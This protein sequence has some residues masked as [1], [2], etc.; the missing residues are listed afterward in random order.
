MSNYS[1]Q[2]NVLIEWQ[3]LHDLLDKTKKEWETFVQGGTLGVES[4]ISPDI[5]SS[6]ERCR[7]RNMNPYDNKMKIVS[8]SELAKRLQ[9]NHTLIEILNPIVHEIMDSI[10]D[11]GYKIDFYDKDLVLLMRFGKKTEETQR[12]RK[13]ALLG[14]SHKEEH[15]GTN[16]TNLAAL[17]EKPIQIVAYQHFR[18]YYHDRTCVSVPLF[19]KEDSLIGVL[20][21][22]G[23]CWPLHKHTMGALIAIKRLVELK[24]PEE[25]KEKLGLSEIVGKELMEFVETPVIVVDRDSNITAINNKA[26]E[27]ICRGWACP[28][29]FTSES[30]WGDNDPFW[31]VLRLRK[32]VINQTFLCRDGTATLLY[33]CDINPVHDNGGKCIGA[34][35]IF[36]NNNINGNTVV[37]ASGFK[38]YYSF[39]SIV[40][41]STSIKR[42]I[43]LARETASMDNNV[44]I[45]GESGTGKE[46]FAQ[47]IHNASMYAT[48]PFLAVNCAAIPNNLLE[49]E[50]FGYEGGAFTG[51]KKSGAPGKFELAKGGTIFLDEI[52]SMSQDMQVKIL[53]VMQNKKVSRI[54]GEREISVNVRIITAANVDLLELVKEG[55]FRED[56]YYRINVISV[57]IPPLRE[58]GNDIELLINN[59]MGRMSAKLGEIVD[60]N[61]DARE[62]LHQYSW[63]GNVRELE[64]V[65]ERSWVIAKTN[66]SRVITKNEIQEFDEFMSNKPTINQEVTQLEESS[67]TEMEIVEMKTIEKAIRDNEGNI[68]K[69]A[70]LLGLSRNTLYRKMKKYSIA[71]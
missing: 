24:L 64:N 49:S 54:G 38:A 55:H 23:Y 17:L 28:I 11:S 60:I 2:G 1:W 70:K 57:M 50:L 33:N 43:R 12:R 52:N 66:N 65:L 36:K 71:K 48:G 67:Y 27:T 44:L 8:E 37:S 3:E 10:K 29:G 53:R 34:I 6:W 40:G 42:A 19:D 25:G 69:T 18:T 47:A 68:Q 5:L 39:D 20:T 21:I 9:D 61:T 13:E 41:E 26:K 58:R 46:L 45:C 30:I 62:L 22:S 56:L 59:I 16:S 31:K 63:P 15:V 7:S 4:C 35:G 32:P 51:A 14:E